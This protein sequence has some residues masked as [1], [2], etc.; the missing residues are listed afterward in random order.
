VSVSEIVTWKYRDAYEAV[1]ERRRARP[2]GYASSEEGIG[3]RRRAT[4]GGG[5][6]GIFWEIVSDA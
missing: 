3:Y 5:R 1:I 2:C 6:S 4:F